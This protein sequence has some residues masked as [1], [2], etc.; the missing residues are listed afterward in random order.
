M[1]TT[2]HLI[3]FP[4]GRF[5]PSL[6][7]INPYYLQPITFFLISPYFFMSQTLNP[8]FPTPNPTPAITLPTLYP[9]PF[10]KRIRPRV[11]Q[12]AVAM[13]V[14]VRES[15]IIESHLEEIWKEGGGGGGVEVGGGDDSGMVVPTLFLVVSVLVAVMYSVFCCRL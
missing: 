10:L 9:L 7:F 12:A 4:K 2:A 14:V 15:T 8:A 13:A 5:T 6:A 1:L 11:P 3:Y